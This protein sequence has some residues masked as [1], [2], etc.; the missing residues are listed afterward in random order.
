VKLSQP[1]RADDGSPTGFTVSPQFYSDELGGK[2]IAVSNLPLEVD[3]FRIGGALP[4][5]QDPRSKEEKC[6][7][8]QISHKAL[9]SRFGCLQATWKSA[10]GAPQRAD[11]ARPVVRARS[12]L[13]PSQTAEEV[14]Y[15]LAWS[16]SRPSHER[17]YTSKIQ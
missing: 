1:I 10:N 14:I 12:I 11:K 6:E 7:P 8:D 9:A 4:L 13:T 16:S 2:V 5:S 15:W 3:T 17:A